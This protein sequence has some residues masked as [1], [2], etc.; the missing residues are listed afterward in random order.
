MNQSVEQG[1]VNDFYLGIPGFR[2]SDLFD[3]RRLAELAEA[4]YREVADKE[5]VLH[6]ALRRYIDGRGQGTE[7]RAASKILTDAA[8]FLSDFIARMFG[9]SAER[10]ELE[11][12][13]LRQNP[14]WKYKFF[15]QRR[16]T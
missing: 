15:V 2:Y 1:H 12:E 16:A 8:P 9:I 10:A 5:P 7:K 3:A 6:D 4:F 14:I 13:I 11:K